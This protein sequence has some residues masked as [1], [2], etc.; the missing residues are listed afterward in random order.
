MLVLGTACTAPPP[1]ESLTETE[2][3]NEPALTPEATQPEDSLPPTEQPSPTET[4]QA[5]WGRPLEPAPI[6][7]DFRA[8]PASVVAATGNPQLIEFFAFW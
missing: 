3:P 7:G 8:D 6:D 2:L 5:L 1:L 4:A